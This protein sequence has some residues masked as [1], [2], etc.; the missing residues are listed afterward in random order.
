M[1]S[2]FYVDSNK[3][4]WVDTVGNNT[5][6]KYPLNYMKTRVGPNTTSNTITD[7]FSKETDLPV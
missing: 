2:L 3:N 7:M 5:G 1:N 4:Y 6:T